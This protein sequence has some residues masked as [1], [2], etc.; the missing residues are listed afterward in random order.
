MVLIY[1]ANGTAICEQ[2]LVC[3][4]LFIQE[5]RDIEELYGLKSGVGDIESGEVAIDIDRLR[6]FVKGL[7]ISIDGSNNRTVAVLL[8][9]YIAIAIDILRASGDRCDLPGVVVADPIRGALTEF[10]MGS[11]LR[12]VHQKGPTPKQL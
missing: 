10:E 4:K 2:R 3:G 1:T 5:T 12:A 8:G 11:N 9:G 6:D 7:L